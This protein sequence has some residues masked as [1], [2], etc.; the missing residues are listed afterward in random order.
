MEIVYADHRGELSEGRVHLN[1]RLFNGTPEDGATKVYILGD[2]P[3]IALAYRALGVEVEEVKPKPD[4]PEPPPPPIVFVEAERKDRDWSALPEDWRFWPWQELRALAK[5]AGK[6]WVINR[7]QAID[8][9]EEAIIAQPTEE[10][11]EDG[12]SDD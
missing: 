7:D 8:A 4:H 1:P 10:E 2:H 11:L 9:V 5:D 3:K 12:K 6:A